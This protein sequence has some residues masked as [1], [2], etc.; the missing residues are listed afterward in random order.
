[1]LIRFRSGGLLELANHLFTWAGDVVIE[2]P[3]ALEAM[4]RDRLNAAWGL[5]RPNLSQ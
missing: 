5:L 2:E 4:M 3:D 1:L